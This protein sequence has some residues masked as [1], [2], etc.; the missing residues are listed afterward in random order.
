MRVYNTNYTDWR[1]T[2][3]PTDRASTCNKGEHFQ[4]RKTSFK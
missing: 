4:V 3:A 2:K 1:I